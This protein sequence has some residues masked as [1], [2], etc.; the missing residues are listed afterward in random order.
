[1]N[2][3]STLTKLAFI[4][5]SLDSLLVYFSKQLT[6]TIIATNLVI[7]LFLLLILAT[8]GI[9]YLTPETRVL[10]MLSISTLGFITGIILL[11]EFGLRRFFEI[12]SALIAFIVGYAF[13]RWSKNS[14][15]V[16][17]IL[18]GIGLIYV[19]TCGIALSHTLP[20][21]FPVINK[22]WALN[23]ALFNR[24]EVTT[25]QNFQIFYLIP[26]LIVLALP[27]R[28]IRL[29]LTIFCFIGSLYVMA[30]LQTRSGFLICFSIA[31][32][33]I[34]APIWTKSLGRKKTI[35]LPVA[36]IITASVFLPLILEYASVLILRFT[37]VDFSTGLG[38]LHSFLYLFDNI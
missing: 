30:K 22:V 3:S 10:V 34:F 37:N 26:G 14:D 27:L 17:P 7:P 12:I 38:R 8:R 15:E 20:S 5:I 31:F 29:A 2:K 35:L 23:G 24:P 13:I 33:C 25:D 36:G 28:K 21:Y 1:M 19:I 32:M 11:P 4:L 16:A 6:G 9:R 18:L